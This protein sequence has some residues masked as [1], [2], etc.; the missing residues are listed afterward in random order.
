[1][2]PAPPGMIAPVTASVP[3]SGYQALST[4]YRYNYDPNM[5]DQY[6][7]RHARPGPGLVVIEN[8]KGA[9]RK[10][11]PLKGK[12]PSASGSTGLCPSYV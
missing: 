6:L 9:P 10:T 8:W 12:L 7:G 4:C 2:A 1:M 3:L 11:E 5:I